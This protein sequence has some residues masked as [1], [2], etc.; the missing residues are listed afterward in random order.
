MK[1]SKALE[2]TSKDFKDFGQLLSKTKVPALADNDEYT[3]WGKIGS[4]VFGE[5]ASSGILLCHKR[6]FIGKSFERHEKTPEVLVALEGDSVLCL[7]K[8]AGQPTEVNWFQI[9]QGDAFM[10]HTGTWH[11]IPFP[12]KTR[13]CRFL[14]I[15]ACG[16]EEGDLNY[17]NLT[18]PMEFVL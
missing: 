7:A 9:H 15:F 8:P 2:F 3:Y 14:V 16:T 10:L 6:A 17:F 4:L 18:D 1:T 5:K 11:C 12:I 13:E